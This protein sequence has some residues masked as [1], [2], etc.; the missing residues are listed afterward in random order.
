MTFFVASLYLHIPFC[1]HKC[2]YCD[3]YSIE[4]L[5]PLET[6]L[7]SLHRE[8]D[9]QRGYGTRERF[10]T[11]FFGGGTPSL[12]TPAQLGDILSHLHRN[13]RIE[14]EAEITMEANPGTVNRES[15]R[16]YQQL[17]INRISFGVQSFFD[18]DLAFLTRIHTSASAREAVHLAQDTGYENVSIDLIFAL[19]RQTMARWEENLRQAVA[20]QPTHI[21]AYS[22]IVETGTPL[23]RMVQTKQVS[24]LPQEKE[25]EMY[26]RSMQFFGDAGFEH[27]EVS[28]YALPGYRSQHNSN[29]WNHTNYL[30]FGPSAHSFWENQRW[31]NVRS[32]E[33]YCSR[34]DAG[35]LPLAGQETLTQS[36]LLDE[37]IML[38]LRSDGIDLRRVEREHGIDLRRSLHGLIEEL[39]GD[40]LAIVDDRSLRLT[41]RGYLLCDEISRR[42]L[43]GLGSK[44]G[45]SRIE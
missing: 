12:L 34:V 6:F 36:Q 15:L 5:D 20:L 21:S 3:F 19:P 22:L 29:Y 45:V 33:G 28:N 44:T 10:T 7:R 39:T 13:F 23:A 40:Q 14:P 31:W 1:E 4:T 24:P 25:A 35:E 37:S 8:I 16:A 26:E 18:D 9:L 42:M 41:N 30:S 38:G 17:G 11:I 27:Y 32:I 2:I 43:R